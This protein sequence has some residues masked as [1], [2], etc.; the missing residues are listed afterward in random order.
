M[1]DAVRQYVDEVRSGAFPSGEHSFHRNRPAP[2]KLAR[3][4]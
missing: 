1:V 2:A 4:Y 3:L